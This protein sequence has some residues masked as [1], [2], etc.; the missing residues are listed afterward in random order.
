M[1]V[2]KVLVLVLSISFSG[3]VSCSQPSAS[4]ST[5]SSICFVGST[6]CDSFIRSAMG[7]PST[8][9]CDFMKWKLCLNASGK[10][11][12]SFELTAL[13]GVSQ[14]NT[15]GFINGGSKLTFTGNYNVSTG[16]RNPQARVF[17]LQDSKS[18]ATLLLIGMDDYILHFADTY[19]QLLVGNGGFGYVLNR[20]K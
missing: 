9:V 12:G 19:K 13:Y 3:S 11:T 4:G 16:A 17:H 1:Q 18:S 8:M 5:I 10:S 7:I 2:M 14:P 15:N 20:V 6:P